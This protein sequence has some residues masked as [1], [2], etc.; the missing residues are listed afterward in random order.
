MSANFGNV[1]MPNAIGLGLMVLGWYISI[2][3]V[4]LARF[5]TNVLLTKWTLWGLIL[6]L[7]G[8]YLPRIWN[9]LTGR[10]RS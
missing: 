6:I 4:G 8:A 7:L 2:L 5:Q 1:I 3:N 9:K 10:M